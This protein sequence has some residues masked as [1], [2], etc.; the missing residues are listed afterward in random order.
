MLLE[1][2]SAAV[3]AGIRVDGGASVAE[4]HPIIC[5]GQLPMVIDVI[6]VVNSSWI[7]P[8]V[9]VVNKLV[10]NQQPSGEPTMA[11]VTR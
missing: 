11:V 4:N 7:Q 3:H 5:C 1:L 2:G 10:H 6:I 8:R 9:I